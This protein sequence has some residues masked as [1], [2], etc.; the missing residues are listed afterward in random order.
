M[1]AVENSSTINV[2]NCKNRRNERRLLM[3]VM[4]K[5]RSRV[6]S[7]LNEDYP[8]VMSERGR[9]IESRMTEGSLIERM[10]SYQ[11]PLRKG[12][13]TTKKEYSIQKRVAKSLYG[14]RYKIAKAIVEKSYET[15][16][17]RGALV[18]GIV[19]VGIPP[20]SA[21]GWI[22]WVELLISREGGWDIFVMRLEKELDIVEY[23]RTRK[24]RAWVY[25]IAI[26]FATMCLG[27]YFSFLSDKNLAPFFT[28]PAFLLFLTMVVSAQTWVDNA[29]KHVAGPPG[30]DSK[31]FIKRSEVS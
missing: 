3:F 22:N 21:P 7:A 11:P 6:F 18:S 15:G 24:A 12:H 25:G 17:A 4:D 31:F 23:Y 20:N 14:K 29:Y 13:I 27:H 10:S 30:K 1:F 16:S 19:S 9:D 2:G 8:I 26:L 5:N 28:A